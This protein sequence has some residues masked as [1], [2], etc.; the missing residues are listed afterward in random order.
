MNYSTIEGCIRQSTNQP[1]R[2]EITP[3]DFK[4][5]NQPIKNMKITT[6]HL[7]DYS[8]D[9]FETF[10]GWLEDTDLLNYIQKWCED[11]QID[12]NDEDNAWTK[13]I[14]QTETRNDLL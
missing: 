10:D 6:L 14:K 9:H 3:K 13:S 2:T 5:I 8:Y 4:Y 7:T 12:Y 11:N 1:M